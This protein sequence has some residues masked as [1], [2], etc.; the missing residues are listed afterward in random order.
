MS[1]NQG[2][3]KG[4]RG[5]SNSVG[6][7]HGRSH[8]HLRAVGGRMSTVNPYMHILLY[9]VES[10]VSGQMLECANIMVASADA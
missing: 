9:V 1:G 4:E 10:S 7:G 2:G 8:R 6:E 3:K 5:I